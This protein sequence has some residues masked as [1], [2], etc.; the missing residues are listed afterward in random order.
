MLTRPGAGTCPSP[1]GD[2]APWAHVAVLVPCRDEEQTVGQVVRAFAAALPGCRVHVCDNGSRDRT[3]A[4]AAQAGALVVHEPRPGKG[5][6]VQRLLAVVDADAYL[7]VDGDGTYDAAAAPDLVRAL[8]EQ[9]GGMVVGARVGRTA[10]ALGRPGHRLGNA[11]VSRLV[12]WLCG[13]ELTDVLSGYRALSR[14]LVEA[15][16]LRAAGFDVEVEL[17]A[18]ALLGRARCAEVATAY[19]ERPA[20]SVS[21]LRTWRDGSRVVVRL[22]VLR[23]RWP[24][25]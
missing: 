3:A 15:L 10:A 25:C 2:D 20:G 9:R 7:L 24:R 11:A 18:R 4:V 5:R 16:P 12:R 17:T 19:A 14:D 21:K 6:A 1:V 8:A 13:G 22:L 23:A